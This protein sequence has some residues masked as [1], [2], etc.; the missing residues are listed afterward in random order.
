ML[1]IW[2]DSE[3]LAVMENI[4]LNL[5]KRSVLSTDLTTGGAF[6]VTSVTCPHTMLMADHAV[7]QRIIGHAKPEKTAFF[8]ARSTLPFI[9]SPFT[10]VDI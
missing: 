8:N 6:S 3:S 10:L 5:K 2:V 9:T 7:T 4:S 1:I